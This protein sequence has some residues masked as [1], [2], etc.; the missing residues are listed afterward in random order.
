MK[1]LIIDREGDLYESFKGA[2]LVSAQIEDIPV[3]SIDLMEKVKDKIPAGYDIYHVHTSLIR[4][5]SKI[6]ELRKENPHSYILLRNN[7]IQNISPEIR[8]NVNASIDGLIEGAHIRD[9][10]LFCKER[11]NKQ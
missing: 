9:A 5:L 4:P 8:S 11:G 2:Y 1:I 3:E 6:V 7:L 10:I